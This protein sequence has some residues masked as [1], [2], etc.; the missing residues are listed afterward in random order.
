MSVPT[1]PLSPGSPLPYLHQVVVGYVPEHD[2]EIRLLVGEVIASVKDLGNGWTL[3]KNVSSGNQVCTYFILFFWRQ[4]V[5][6]IGLGAH[7][8][9]IV[10]LSPLLENNHPT[11]EICSFFSKVRP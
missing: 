6:A 1:T 3:G 11:Q 5:D 10:A 8:Q 4:N 7:E 2:G 9:I